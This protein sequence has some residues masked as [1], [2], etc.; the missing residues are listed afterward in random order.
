M[1][2]AEPPPCLERWSSQGSSSSS[3]IP[4]A[5][6][7]RL[8]EKRSPFCK[9]CGKNIRKDDSEGGKKKKELRKVK[10]EGELPPKMPLRCA[11]G[12]NLVSKRLEAPKLPQR[13]TETISISRSTL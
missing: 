11:E 1:E 5:L 2:Y 13:S 10:S 4:P 7:K 3:K 6:P 12:F 9:S 8:V